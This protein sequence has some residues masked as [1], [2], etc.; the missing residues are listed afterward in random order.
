MTAAFH[1]ARFRPCPARRKTNGNARRRL[2]RPRW[3]NLRP[4]LV[5]SSPRCAA[6][7]GPG[8]YP[9]FTRLTK[10]KHPL[11]VR[12]YNSPHFAAVHFLSAREDTRVTGN[13]DKFIVHT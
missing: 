12:I 6:A 9:V 7:I 10:A 13:P 5:K 3:R 1:P 11:Y 8:A 2:S 4:S